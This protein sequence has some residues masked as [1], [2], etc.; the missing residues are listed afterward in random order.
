M[1]NGA[2]LALHESKAEVSYRQGQI[3]DYATTERNMLHQEDAE[4][5]T[6]FGVEFVVE[7]TDNP[8]EWVGEGAGEKGYLWRDTAAD[9]ATGRGA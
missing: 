8:Y 2:Y 6:K 9:V 4:P 1:R 5:Q 3:V 7:A